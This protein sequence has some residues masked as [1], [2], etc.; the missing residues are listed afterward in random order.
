[1]T[2]DFIEELLRAIDPAVSDVATAAQSRDD[3]IWLAIAGTLTQ[4][5]PRHTRH[6]RR[7]LGVSALGASVVALAMLL[8]SVFSAPTSAVAGTLMAAAA[9]DSRAA[10]LPTLAAGQ[11]YYQTSQVSLMC[12]FAGTNPAPD[13]SLLTYIANG[14]MQSWTGADGSG[15]VV[16]TPSAVGADGSHFATSAD[17]ARWVALGRPFIPCALGDTSNQFAGNPANTNRQGTFGGY[18]T[19]VS[20]FGGFGLA[21]ASSSQTSLLNATTSINNLPASV[22]ALSSLLAAGQINADGSVSSTPQVCP[23]L[24]G[25]STTGIGCTP[26]EELSVIEQLL[27]LPDASAKLGSVFYKVLANLPNARLVGSVATANGN[28]GTGVQVPQGPNQTLQVVFDPTTGALLSCSE[29]STT[30]GVASSIGSISYSPVQV[31]QG[32]VAT[33]TVASNQ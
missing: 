19:T 31:T 1:M 9:V 29:L 6:T 12:S 15:K 33:A 32:Q 24:D 10:A 13:E 8:V 26:S 11:Y 18:A 20:G 5:T 25:T 30:G 4:E 2:T 16:I 28:I 3:E 27:Q 17:Q 23:V 21:L 7:Y 14:T 22:A